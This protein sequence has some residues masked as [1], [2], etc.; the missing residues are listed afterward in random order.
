MEKNFSGKTKGE[1]KRNIENTKSWQIADWKYSGQIAQDMMPLLGAPLLGEEKIDSLKEILKDCSQYYPALIE[2]GYRYIKEGKDKIGKE[3]IDKGLQSLKRHFS[4]KNLIDA[5]YHLCQFLE[6]HLRFKMAIEY[7][8]Q[9]MELEKDKAKMYDYISYCYSYLGDMEKAFESQQKALDLCDSNH[10]FY[11]NMGWIEIIRGNLDAAKTLLEKSLELNQK[12]EIA[13]N[14]YEVC[15]L[16]LKSK[17]LKNWEAYLLRKIDYEYL[18]KLEDEDDMEEYEEQGRL[19]NHDK[20]GAFKFDLMRNPNYTLAEKY[21]ILFI[22]NHILDFIWNLHGSTFFFYNDISGV[23]D[24]LKP[25]M[26]K[27]IFKTGDIDEKVFND[28]YTALLEF[29]KFL[30]KRKVVSGYKWLENK[31]VKLK[32]EL[33]KK[34][35]RY[36]EIRH[37]DEYTEEEKDEIREEL[38]EGDASWPFL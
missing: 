18:E 35:A 19:Y 36:N 10:R 25:I 13:L 14:N 15:K 28:I 37:S 12:D 38:F 21:D 34:M 22:L 16:M 9:L 17:Q 1:K 4:K 26:H 24:Y 30:T 33:M 29:Y 11:S 6:K 5:Y 23:R 3:S 31:M 2:L 20:I 27:F 7:Y 32:P 8:N